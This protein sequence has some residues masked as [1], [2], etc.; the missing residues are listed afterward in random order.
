[1]AEKKTKKD[2]SGQQILI[3]LSLGLSVVVALKLFLPKKQNG[4]GRQQLSAEETQLMMMD[5]MR[6]QQQ[7]L[8]QTPINYPQQLP[9][10]PQFVEVPTVR[11]GAISSHQEEMLSQDQLN[12]IPIREEVGIN[13]LF[14]NAQQM[15][16]QKNTINPYNMRNVRMYQPQVP[17]HDFSRIMIPEEGTITDASASRLR[18]QVSPHQSQYSQPTGYSTNPYANGSVV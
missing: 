16:P 8:P 10:N 4:N 18:Q 13:N 7:A 2:L 1:M 14:A 3:Y 6:A 9:A 12:R 17:V 5:M 11:K 15:P